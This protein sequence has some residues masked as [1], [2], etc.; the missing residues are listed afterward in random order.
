M[1]Y[2]KWVA[3]PKG[4]SKS[5]LIRNWREKAPSRVKN[6][7]SERGISINN[8]QFQRNYTANNIVNEASNRIMYKA[9][10]LLRHV[11]IYSSWKLHVRKNKSP[12]WRS[13][14]KAITTPEKR[15]RVHAS[16]SLC[17]THK[18]LLAQNSKFKRWPNMHIFLSFCGKP[19]SMVFSRTKFCR[20]S[21]YCN[22]NPFSDFW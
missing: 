16:L 20:Q 12:L 13:Q 11:T 2:W 14:T 4:V 22:F 7:R 6:L 9:Q 18:E 1:Y 21:F 8:E 3:A 10:T 15:L 5:F 17:C 19:H